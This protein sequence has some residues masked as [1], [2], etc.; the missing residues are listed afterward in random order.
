[1]L[2]INSKKI[3]NLEQKLAASRN[4]L[5]TL[6]DLRGITDAEVLAASIEFDDLLNQ[7]QKVRLLKHKY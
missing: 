3:A 1:M 4:K 2:Q 6:W 7:Y 5:Q